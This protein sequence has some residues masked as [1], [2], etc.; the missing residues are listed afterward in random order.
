MGENTPKKNS[1]LVRPMTGAS[2]HCSRDSNSALYLIYRSVTLAC[3]NRKNG[4]LLRMGLRMHKGWN[5]KD[6]AGEPAAVEERI[7]S[8]AVCY[9]SGKVRPARRPGD[10]ESSR[11]RSG[12][13]RGVFSGLDVRERM[14]VER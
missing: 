6:V 10:Y 1:K 8:C 5:L 11:W 12:E 13:F 9:R 2:L 14:F 3:L 4:V 7:V